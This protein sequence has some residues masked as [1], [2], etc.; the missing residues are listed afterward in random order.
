[1]NSELPEVPTGEYRC[2]QPLGHYQL[3]LGYKNLFEHERASG[4]QN[5]IR[6]PRRIVPH[7]ALNPTPRPKIDGACCNT[8]HLRDCTKVIGKRVSEGPSTRE[9][10]PRLAR[11]TGYANY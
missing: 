11:S 1:M 7:L 2:E 5:R 9:V 3:T 4:G 10:E 8:S 6:I